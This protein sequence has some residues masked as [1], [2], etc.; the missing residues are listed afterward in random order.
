MWTL[1][2]ITTAHPPRMGRK[3][4]HPIQEANT[5][6]CNKNHETN[7]GAT[8]RTPRGVVVVVVEVVVV[9]KAGSHIWSVSRWYHHGRPCC[10][11]NADGK[12]EIGKLVTD[13]DSN[14]DRL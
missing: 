9:K 13:R 3:G 6:K 4:D 8:T 1:V 12:L 2:T 5:S 7:S 14:A 10:C 11:Q